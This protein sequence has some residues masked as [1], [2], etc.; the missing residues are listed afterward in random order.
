MP[1]FC[2]SCGNAIQPNQNFCN[3]CGQQSGQLPPQQNPKHTEPLNQSDPSYGW[4]NEQSHPPQHPLQRAPQN[5]PQQQA[6]PYQTAAKKCPF[7][8]ETI[9]ADAIKCRFCGEIVD[10]TRRQNQPQM[11][12]INQNVNVAVPVNQM[13]APYYPQQKLWSPGVAALLSFIIPGL[14]QLY[15]GQ[16]GTGIL[17][18]VVVIIGYALFVVPGLILH[19]ICIVTA[20]NG[21]PY[22]R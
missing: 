9:N 3:K 5:V 17:W 20:A 1:T 18:F 6:Q 15:K 19:I 7:C 16:I 4:M 22:Q 13:A 2:H 11:P 10:I 14:G 8:A 21:S 12:I